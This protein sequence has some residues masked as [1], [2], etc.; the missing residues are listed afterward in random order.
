M[1]RILKQVLQNAGR[2]N[3]VSANNTTIVINI[4]VTEVVEHVKKK[5]KVHAI[6]CHEGTQGE[7]RGIAPPFL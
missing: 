5:G 2:V 3:S 6:T 7:S 1:L 4:R